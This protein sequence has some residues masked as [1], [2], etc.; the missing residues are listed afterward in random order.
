LELA[1]VT[2]GSATSAV[3]QMVSVKSRIADFV[4]RL[5]RARHTDGYMW[6]TVR[7]KNIPLRQNKFFFIFGPGAGKSHPIGEFDHD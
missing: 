5:S 2:A 3:A 6:D 1:G 4:I 7:E